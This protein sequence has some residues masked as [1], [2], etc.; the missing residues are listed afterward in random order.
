[1]GIRKPRFGVVGGQRVEFNVWH[2][3]TDSIEVQ[4]V[5][6]EDSGT[7]F[8]YHWVGWNIRV[9]CAVC[10]AVRNVGQVRSIDA[11]LAKMAAEETPCANCAR[12]RRIREAAPL[13][14]AELERLTEVVRELDRT[15]AHV[16]SL[17][18]PEGVARSVAQPG[19]GY[20]VADSRRQA[21]DMAI[22]AW[23]AGW[24][25]VGE[26][27]LVNPPPATLPFDPLQVYGTEIDQLKPWEGHIWEA[28][29]RLEQFFAANAA[30][31]SES[32]S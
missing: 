15:T 13:V 12:I 21:A 9:T 8:P 22:F 24:K 3:V 14:R 26:Q 20:Y 31:I 4:P 10:A 28:L 27:Y 16:L 7:F 18:A 19:S 17:G 32:E 11:T 30:T 5:S 23:H 29:N 6:R 1:M 2:R 25:T